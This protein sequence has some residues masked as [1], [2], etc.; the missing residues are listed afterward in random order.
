MT[1]VTVHFGRLYDLCSMFDARAYWNGIYANAKSSSFSW[2]QLNPEASLA[3]I[4]ELPIDRNASLIDVG[5]G[6]GLLSDF[7]LRQ[8]YT[9]ITV[10]DISEQ[11]ISKAKIRLGERANRVKWIVADVRTFQPGQT[12]DLWHDRAV[13]HFLNSADDQAAYIASLQ[14]STRPFSHL[15]ISTFSDKGPDMCSGLPV[16]RYSQPELI[17]RFSEA[18]D[19]IGGVFEDHISPGGN[20]QNFIYG[21][22]VRRN[23]GDVNAAQMLRTFDTLET[24]SPSC[25]LNA[26][27]CCC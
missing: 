24:Q 17:H 12:Y 22:F 15:L 4:A 19:C 27:G 11:A 20:V 9:N 14:R 5:G 16:T 13:F 7:L 8:G 21:L 2:E 18:F 1:W 26:K 3:L 23:P 25:D 10:L 6:D